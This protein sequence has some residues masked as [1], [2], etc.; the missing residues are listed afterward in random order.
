MN[1]ATLS[2]PVQSPKFRKD[3]FG[4]ALVIGAV[5]EALM[6]GELIYSNLSQPVT[7]KPKP[8]IMA[9][10]MTRKIAEFMSDWPS[11]NFW[12]MPARLGARN[13]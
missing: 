8:K 1:A 13:E 9:I 6:I 4:R 5:I 10:H 11:I 3:H 2:S 7:V 12:W